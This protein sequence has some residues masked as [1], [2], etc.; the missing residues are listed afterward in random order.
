MPR[1]VAAI[2]CSLIMVLIAGGCK[3]KE[4]PG[5]AGAARPT[6]PAPAVTPPAM[7]QPA[8]GGPRWVCEQPVIDY[9][10]V[11][12]DTVVERRFT[13]WNAGKQVLTLGKPLAR[14]S[15]SSAPEYSKEV[16]PG[17][18]GTITYALK[19]ERKPYGPCVE[20]ITFPT[21]DPAAPKVQVTLKG[22]IHTAVDP[23]VVYDANYERDKAAGKAGE[24]PT[25]EGALFG[26][27]KSEDRLHRVIRLHNT[28]GRPLSLT[29]PPGS[30][31]PF[32]VELKQLAADKE[33]ELVVKMD[34]PIRVGQWYS[35]VNLQTNIPEQPVYPVYVAAEVP[36]RVEIVPP[37][38]IVIDQDLYPQKERQ[39]RI[40]NHGSTPVDI[41]AISTSEPRYDIKL[42]PRDP[43]KPED[44]VIN[45]GLPGG[46]N[47]RPP[48][49]GEAIEIKTNDREVPLIHIQILPSLTAPIAP[50]PPDKPLQMYPVKL[51]G[52]GGG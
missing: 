20:Y 29:M 38:K 50:R 45:I 47:Y 17:G 19:T 26:R 36:P 35:I 14:C 23:E 51:P 7:A 13:F 18:T 37:G 3:P 1:H 8:Q 33:Y 43:A 24:P 48:A 4:A 28:S 39:I 40:S 44:Q 9:G 42:L 15:C 31:A 12:V 16:P 5:G 41:I 21:N 27:V 32:Q 11:W 30:G 34:P 6:A 46:S 52:A 2:G 10:E 22:F 49:Y 25:K